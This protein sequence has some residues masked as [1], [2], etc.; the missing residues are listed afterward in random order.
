MYKPLQ[1][2]AP[3]SRKAK[4][5]PLNRPP[6]ISPRGLVLGNCPQIQKENKAKLYT[7]G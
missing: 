3:Q 7:N 4:N 2:Y 1:I 5:P 6:S